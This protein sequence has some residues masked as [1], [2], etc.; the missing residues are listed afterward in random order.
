M[1][2]AVTDVVWQ[3]II[4]GV[5]TLILAWMQTRTQKTVKEAAE[6]SASRGA[7][8]AQKVDEVS[9]DLH[10]SAAEVRQTQAEAALATRDKLRQIAAVGEKA[11][12]VG[13]M[14]HALVN[15]AMLE[16]KRMLMVKCQA[17]AQDH[18]S[19]TNVAEAKAAEEAYREHRAKQDRMEGTP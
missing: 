6:A 11:A 4:A 5:V 17:A 13:Q 3:A 12:A 14:T 15:S 7:A 8:A 1:L 18:P 19:A 10:D 16:Q 2:L 9:R